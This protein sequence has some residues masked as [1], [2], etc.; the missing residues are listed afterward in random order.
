MVS[1]LWGVLKG[2]LGN[3]FGCVDGRAPGTPDAAS[4]NPAGDASEDVVHEKNSVLD[5]PGRLVNRR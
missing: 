1:P 5:V 3:K 2:R 4:G